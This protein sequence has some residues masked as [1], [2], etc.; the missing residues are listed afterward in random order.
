[1]RVVKGYDG[2]I[3]REDHTSIPTD[4]SVYLSTCIASTL[5]RACLVICIMCSSVF[6]LSIQTLSKPVHDSLVFSAVCKALS[7]LS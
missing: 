4:P 6:N 2:I 5:L 7:S 1:M 3:K